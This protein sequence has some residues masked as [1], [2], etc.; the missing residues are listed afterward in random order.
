MY[1]AAAIGAGVGGYFI[2]HELN[3]SPHRP[4]DQ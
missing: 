4:H 1:S 2:Y 3:E